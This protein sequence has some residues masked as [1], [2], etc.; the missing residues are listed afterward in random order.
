MNLKS[1]IIFLGCTLLFASTAAIFSPRGT[2]IT[3][4]ASSSSGQTRMTIV[5]PGEEKR[6][7]PPLS[8]HRVYLPY[9]RI[10]DGF[11][12]RIYIRNTNV[13]T[14]MTATLSLVGKHGT[15]TISEIKIESTQTFSMDVE[16]AFRHH[17]MPQSS[18]GNALIEFLAE[19]PGAINA[20]AQIVNQTE[21]IAFSFPFQHTV[22]EA[23]SK[24]DGVVWFN[25]RETDAFFSI[26]NTSGERVAAT[27]ILFIGRHPMKLA[28]V[29]LKEFEAKTIKIPPMNGKVDDYPLSAGITIEHDGA[30]G[31]VIA[32]GWA[33]N[34]AR[35]FST[36]FSF[37]STNCDCKPGEKRHLYGTG[38]PIGVSAMMQGAIFDPLLIL[39]N[40]SQGPIKVA[41]TFNFMLGDIPEKVRLPNVTL[42]KQETRVTNLRQ[43]QQAGLIPDVIN[44]GSIELEFESESGGLIAELAS[45]SSTGF[46]TSQVPLVCSGKNALH[47]SYWRT[48]GD[49]DSMLQIE[50]ISKETTKAEITISYPGGLYIFEKPL[51]AGESAMISIKELQQTQ[52][53]DSKGNVIPLS[54]TTGGV[55]I[56]SKDVNQALVINGMIVNAV[57]GTCGFCGAFGTVQAY[58]LTDMP[59]NCFGT[60][61]QDYEVNETIPL[62]MALYFDT[63]QCGSDSVQNIQISTPSIFQIADSTTLLVVGIGS[64][65]FSAETQQEWSGTEDPNCQSPY[66]IGDTA[67]LQVRPKISGPTVVWWFNGADPGNANMPVS[68]SLTTQSGGTS[69]SWTATANAN[70][71]S[72][73]NATT[74]TVTVTGAAMSGQVGDVKIKVT[75]NGVASDEYAITVKAPN[76]LNRTNISHAASTN[77]GYRTE[78]TY[79][80][81][82]QFNASLLAGDLPVN[83]DFTT[84]AVADFPGMNWLITADGGGT[85]NGPVVSDVIEGEN[86]TKNPTPQ[87]PQN[88]LGTTKV[89]HWGQDIYIGSTMV[90]QGK[91]VQTATFQ[92]YRDHANHENIT[93]PVP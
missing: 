82:D 58:G 67:A 83:E 20:F 27:P 42:A 78:I 3:R 15:V 9:W 19:A 62:Y 48:D 8:K 79:S 47:M 32:Q 28:R 31:T 14:P 26:Y 43:Y 53:P 13:R 61:F 35:G 60:A 6:F 40:T 49:W 74:N 92:K 39:R 22:S 66:H 30:P 21:S 87:A 52:L 37:T 88:P 64:G 29:N 86:L 75:V 7:N 59:Q 4:L 91:K 2:V 44:T 12:T 25:D 45:V 11:Y 84:N 16:E 18:D 57:T 65:Q 34:V 90:G 77:F 85:L 1:V 24:L 56:W 55:N 46:Y 76:Q 36:G 89:V 93:S 10:H 69:Y 63:S 54:A 68:I 72:L 38:V 73:Q 71:V 51:K 17:S 81:R 33:T 41:P 5:S 23:E 80:I 50:N 70:K